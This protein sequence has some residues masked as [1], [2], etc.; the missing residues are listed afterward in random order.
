MGAI[1]HDSLNEL[2]FEIAVENGLE[3]WPEQHVDSVKEAVQ[4]GYPSTLHHHRVRVGDLDHKQEPNAI[5]AGREVVLEILDAQRQR[6]RE[7]LVESVVGLPL[8]KKKGEITRQ[9][10]SSGLG[11]F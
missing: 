3:A 2:P 7:D 10:V 1:M 8:R 4:H 11:A 9:K 5:A 6:P